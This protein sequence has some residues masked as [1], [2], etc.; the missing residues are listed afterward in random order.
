MTSSSGY[1]GKQGLLKLKA[2]YDCNLAQLLAVAT[3]STRHGVGGW[4]TECYASS[5]TI[6]IIK[7]QKYAT[8]D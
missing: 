1:L 4:G 8:S 2:K 3:A 7:T 5:E 6:C